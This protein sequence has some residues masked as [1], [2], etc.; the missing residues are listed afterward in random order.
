MKVRIGVGAG[1]HSSTGTELGQ[2]VKDLE[3]LRFDS[4]WLADLLSLPGDDP[5]T[6]LAYAAGVAPKLKI[7][8]TMVLPGRNPVRLAKQIATLDRV[9]GGRLLLTF[10]FGIKQPTELA[11]M[12][13]DAT[14]R[15]A[16]VDEVLPLV[17]RL[18]TEDGVDHAGSAYRFEGVTVEPKPLQNPLDVWLGGN[19]PSSLRRAG[20]LSDGWLPSMCLPAEAAAGR[21]TIEEEAEK[22]GRAIDPEHFGVSIGYFRGEA[23]PPRL[24]R[25]AGRRTDAELAELVP[26]GIP[27]LRTLLERYLEVGFS[28]FVVRPLVAP[29]SWR[30]ELEDLAAGVLDLQV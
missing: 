26:N 20:A 30:G 6:G 27:A 16:L 10:V 15:G 7:G 22:A 8:T 29:A 2:L 9:S 14:Q 3:E 1:L 18:W 24:G 23:P 21:R 28:K 13:V 5:L 4:I 25:L 19:V 17:R 11:A 12:G